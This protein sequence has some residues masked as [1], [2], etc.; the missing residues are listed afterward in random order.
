M[1]HTPGKEAREVEKEQKADER[2]TD[3]HAHHDHHTGIA[4]HCAGGRHLL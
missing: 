1:Y 4:E 2:H 3:R